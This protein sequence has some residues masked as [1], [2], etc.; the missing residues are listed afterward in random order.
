MITS[1][2]ANSIGRNF[3]YV[4]EVL[5]SKYKLD[6]TLDEG[7]SLVAECLNN[8]IDNPTQNSQFVVV[9]KDGIRYLKEHEIK[10]LFANLDEEWWLCNLSW[11]QWIFHSFLIFSK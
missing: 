2:R 1:F 11:T 10:D 4:N 5:E 6:M 7:L 9:G 8:G 3:K